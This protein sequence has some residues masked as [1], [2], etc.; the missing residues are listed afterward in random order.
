MIRRPP[1]STLFPYTTL[2][3][4]DGTQ[5]SYALIGTDYQCT[6]IKDRNGNFI[7]INYTGFGRVD[8]VV[9]TLNRSI[10]FNYDASNTLT[11]ITQT[12][13]GSPHTWATFE[14]RNPSLTISTAFT[15]LTTLGVQNGSI[16]KVLSRV[17][18][19]DNSRFE[20]DYTSWGQVSK[21]SRIA[22]DGVSLLN[23]RSY[24]LPLDNTTAPTDCPRFT[25]PP[26]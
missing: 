15:G 17:I 19:A 26:H 11:S 10:K 3:R 24:N 16:L 22:N 25:A 13:N 6:E 2:F 23:Y 12:W 1:R 14:Y 4:S 7:T 8:T 9:D 5:L 18:L 20:F 21:I